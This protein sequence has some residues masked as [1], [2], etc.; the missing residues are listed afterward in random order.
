MKCDIPTR[1]VDESYEAVKAGMQ[2]QNYWV[3]FFM[4]PCC[5]APDEQTARHQ[6]GHLKEDLDS[7]T[8]MTEEQREELKSIADERLEWYLTLPVRHAG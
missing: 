4:R 8:D 7:R 6:I 3:R 1:H 2:T 5:P